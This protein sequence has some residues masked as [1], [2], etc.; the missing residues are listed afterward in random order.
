VAK[1]FGI[2]REAQDQF[3]FESQVKAGKAQ[4][5]GCFK[6]QIVPI[7]LPKARDGSQ[8]VFETDEY[9]KA[10][11]TLESL[12][13]L[14][15]A[16]DKANGT[17]TAGSA[18]GINDGAALVV[19]MSLAKA[20]E[21]KLTPLAKIVSCASAAID[22]T[23]MGVGPVA[24][25]KKALCKASWEVRDLDVVESNEAFASQS[26]AVNKEMQWDTAK[27]NPNGGS[28]AIGHPIGASGA[29]IFVDLLHEMKRQ[30]SGKTDGRTVKGLATLCIGGGQGVAC[31]VETMD[32]DVTPRSTL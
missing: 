4:A 8:K 9:I 6:D 19:V 23:I 5:A 27:V 32:D 21:L 18:S 30:Q 26:L 14:R 29:R 3:A 15:P 13:K 12:K 20:T 28:I 25:S 24:A 1:K 31:C 7:L 16:F 17:V 22:P 2:T 10:N 11:C